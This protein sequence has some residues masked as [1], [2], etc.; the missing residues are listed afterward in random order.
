MG[1]NM[2]Q[3]VLFGLVVVTCWQRHNGQRSRNDCLVIMIVFTYMVAISEIHQTNYGSHL[4]D[5]SS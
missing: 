2:F 1:S 3:N 4:W 5:P